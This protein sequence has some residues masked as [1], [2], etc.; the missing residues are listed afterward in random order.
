MKN[1]LKVNLKKMYISI[2][3]CYFSFTSLQ[4]KP[5]IFI[6]LKNKESVN[7]IKGI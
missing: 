7:Y 2:N 3:F 5:F 6:H 1:I 4:R